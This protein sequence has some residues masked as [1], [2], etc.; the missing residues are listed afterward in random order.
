MEYRRFEN[1]C[2]LRLDRGEEVLEG[3]KKLC[4][5]EHIRLAAVTGIGAAR[6]AEI[7]IFD[8]EQRKFIPTKLIGAYEIA[9]CTG[10]VT[11]MDGKIYIHL[12]AVLGNEITGECHAGH[13]SRCVIGLTGELF[14][15]VIDGEVDRLYS[16]ETGLNQFL[17][18]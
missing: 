3:I 18:R 16:S 4:E 8:P 14:L 9:S 12:H 11:Q 13:L 7:G 6:E 17:F 2:V 1:D 10:N 15:H 5:Q